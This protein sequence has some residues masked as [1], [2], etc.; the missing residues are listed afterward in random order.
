MMERS[1]TKDEKI[2]RIFKKIVDVALSNPP[3]GAIEYSEALRAFAPIERGSN[4]PY[5]VE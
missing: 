1:E 5:L 3:S 4:H 2:N